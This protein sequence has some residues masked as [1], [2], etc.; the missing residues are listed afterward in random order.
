MK[1]DLALAALWLLLVAFLG[2]T[3]L[4]FVGDAVQLLARQLVF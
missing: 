2:V 3:T 1:T 4:R